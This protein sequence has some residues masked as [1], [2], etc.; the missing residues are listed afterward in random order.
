MKRFFTKKTSCAALMM[1]ESMS[2][3][4]P[5]FRFLAHSRLPEPGRDYDPEVHRYSAAYVNPDGYGLTVDAFPGADVVEVIEDPEP[6]QGGPDNQEPIIIKR[7]RVPADTVAFDF[8]IRRSSGGFEQTVSRRIERLEGV[9]NEAQSNAAWKLGVTVPMQGTYTCSVRL[10]NQSGTGPTREASLALRDRLVV[11][12]GD[13]FASGEGNP[14]EPGEVSGIL[15][16]GVCENA[17]A[18]IVIKRTAPMRRVASWLEPRGHRSMRSGHVRG[19]DAAQDLERGRVVTLLSF[20]TSGAEVERGLLS[21]Q[22]DWQSALGG[23][24]EEAKRAIGNRPVDA[25]L[26]SIGGNDVGFA[27]GLEGLAGDW[28]DGGRDEMVRSTRQRIDALADCFE[29]MAT[30]VQSLVNPRRV[31]ITEYPAGMFDKRDPS[32][33]SLGVRG[34]GC[35]VFDSGIF[36]RV[37]IDDAEAIFDLAHQLNDQIKRA[38]DR[39]GWTYL[40]G[41]AEGFAGHGYCMT[42]VDRFFVLAEESCHSQGDLRARCTRTSAATRC[43]KRSLRM[44]CDG[45]SRMVL[46]SAQDAWSRSCT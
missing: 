10:R 24:V 41:I 43:T 45:S 23:Q 13:S 34:D 7:L 44:C 16:E 3:D 46:S 38:A 8:T 26:L 32:G 40:D 20:A 29:K 18:N 1:G 37:S 22:H 17:T 14:D 33:R 36:M 30:Q 11:V 19:S 28:R 9:I 6:Q 12:L 31:Y 35:G 42:G 5:T 39:Y 15:G 21:A 4:V 25:L 2:N 27:S